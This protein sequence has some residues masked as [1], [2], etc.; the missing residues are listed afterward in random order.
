[1]KIREVEAAIK[2]ETPVAVGKYHIRRAVPVAVRQG[3]RVSDG[4]RSDFLG[5][6]ANDGVRVRYLDDPSDGWGIGAKRAGEEG[7]VA[8]TEV[9]GS[10]EEISAQRE[11]EADRERR[12]REQL[13][14]SRQRAVVLAE[15]LGGVVHVYTSDFRVTGYS[16]RLSLDAAEALADRETS[17]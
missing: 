6:H 10:W 16:V 12:V 1:M 11:T 4:S 13:E 9:L 14:A 8:P 15:R 5:H 3:R 17:A 2:A 7:V